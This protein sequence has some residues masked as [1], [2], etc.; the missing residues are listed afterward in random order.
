MKKLIATIICVVMLAAMVGCDSTNGEISGDPD[1]VGSVTENNQPGQDT[2]KETT[3]DDA[4][5]Q[6]SAEAL[7]MLGMTAEQ[8][9]ALDPDDQKAL[10]DEIGAVVDNNDKKPST[11]TKPV[12][13]TPDDVMSG[14]SYVVVLGD[15]MNSITLYYENGVLVKLVE[16]FQKSFEEEVFSV[17]YEGQALEEY[18]FNFIDWSGATLQEIL[19]GMR[20]YGGFDNYT[21]RKV[22]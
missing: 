13:Y 5:P 18:G 22:N 14:G 21:I 17:T 4:A 19:D 10:L 11:E 15:Y 2:Q 16:D 8:F 7:E 12:T 20:D 3:D 9:A 1:K 6:I